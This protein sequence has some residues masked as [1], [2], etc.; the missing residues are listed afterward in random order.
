MEWMS[1]VVSRIGRSCFLRRMLSMSS[2]TGRNAR[3]KMAS[4]GAVPGLVPRRAI[5]NFSLPSVV[6][7]VV[8]K[9]S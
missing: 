6:N 5:A 7:H 2:R 4:A 9:P 3:L 1:M 8:V